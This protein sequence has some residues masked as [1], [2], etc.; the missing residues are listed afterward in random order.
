MTY[1]GAVVPDCFML[2]LA[3]FFSV[4]DEGEGT[5]GDYFCN[6]MGRHD[7]LEG[8]RFNWEKHAENKLWVC[9]LYVIIENDSFA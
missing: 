3:I 4:G 5:W 1:L 8:A 7:T 2:L 6:D 9:D